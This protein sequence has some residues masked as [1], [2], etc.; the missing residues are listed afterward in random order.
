MAFLISAASILQYLTADFTRTA[1]LLVMTLRCRTGAHQGGRGRPAA[2][3]ISQ[4][5]TA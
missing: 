5:D 2:R 1:G 4:Q 3:K